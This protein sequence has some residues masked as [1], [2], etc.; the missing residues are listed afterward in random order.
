MYIS[1]ARY[2]RE[3]RIA[4]HFWLALH[5]LE[6]LEG[7][8]SRSMSNLSHFGFTSVEFELF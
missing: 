5:G 2:R 6:D 8:E 4:L 3:G 7:L 1:V